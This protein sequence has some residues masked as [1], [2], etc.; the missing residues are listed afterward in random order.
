VTRIRK[1]DAVGFRGV[2]LAAPLEFTRTGR[3][4]V[5]F[6]ANGHGKSSYVDALD[7]YFFNRIGHLERENVSRAAYRH[8][9]HPH[10]ELASVEIEFSD[11]NKN[12]SLTVDGARHVAFVAGGSEAEAFR[13]TAR[14]ERIILRHRDLSRFVDMTKR[15]KLAD[16]APLLGMEALDHTRTELQAVVRQLE[17]E[18]TTRGQLINER[19]QAVVQRLGLERFAQPEVWNA[20]NGQLRLLGVEEQVRAAA[21]L[22][23]VIPHVQVTADPSRDERTRDLQRASGA[24]E[25]AIGMTDPFPVVRSFLTAF[26]GLTADEQALQGLALAGLW[27]VGLGVLHSEW[28]EGSQCP[29]CQQPLAD[30]EDVEG[31]LQAKLESAQEIRSRRAELEALRDQALSAV[32][33][34]REALASAVAAA[35]PFGESEQF[36][37]VAREAAPLIQTVLELLQAKIERAGTLDDGAVR[38]WDNANSRLGELARKALAGLAEAV[39]AL[40]I[41]EDERTRLDSFRTLSAVEAELT[42]LHTLV[43]EHRVIDIQTRSMQRVLRA[44]EEHERRSMTRILSEI[45]ANVSKYYQRL[46]GGER[47]ANVRLAFL[48][49]ERGLEFSL[50]AFGE[51]VSPPRLILSESHLNSLGLC[52][53]LAAAREFN[54]QTRFIILDD[55][56]NS[57]DADHRGQLA[58][59]LIHE[60]SDFQIMA[61]THDP[62]WFDILRRMAPAWEVRRIV[63]WSYE[64]GV[65]IEL[66]AGDERVRIERY[67]DQGEEG[68]GGNLARQYV[69]R[70]LKDLCRDLRAPIPYREG[71]A[72]EQRSPEELFQALWR[73]VRERRQFSGRDDPAWTEF[74]ASPFLANL[75]SHDQ[76]AMPIPV[77]TGDVRFA[78]E[79]LDQVVDLFRCPGPCGKW[80][81]RLRP[82]QSSDECQCECGNLK[83]S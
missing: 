83:F 29:L 73:H 65:Q 59:L 27:E 20:I 8:R 3:S 15:E 5:V 78:L 77:S 58:D 68:I 57:F 34:S 22:K 26:N 25:Q 79:K 53:F 69:E 56:V 37:A 32:R 52:L 63:G 72:N 31:H 12:G 28:W 19:R 42:R 48:P 82:D 75:A 2:R 17:N 64:L 43:E 66:P 7:C 70:R 45:S 81:W 62:I 13:Q 50:E 33:S 1:L 46:H 38:Q 49:K 11:A 41:S 36:V 9:A 60:F 47:Y 71:Y 44:F 39:S 18:R 76:P 55:I 74:R 67:L 21:D 54:S 10:D 6:G 16:L 51:E 24:I 61:F 30:R 4:M 40:A 35:Q 80:V 14:Q 23:H